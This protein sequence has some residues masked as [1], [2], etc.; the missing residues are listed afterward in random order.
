MTSWNSH[1]VLIFLIAQAKPMRQRALRSARDEDEEEILFLILLILLILVHRRSDR[2]KHI[3]G[4]RTLGEKEIQIQGRAYVRPRH[5]EKV[6]CLGREYHHRHHRG[7]RGGGKNVGLGKSMQTPTHG[8][9]TAGRFERRTE[10][11]P[12]NSWISRT[13]AQ[14]ATR[15][16][17]HTSARRAT[18][19]SRSL[20]YHTRRKG[21]QNLQN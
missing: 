4:V 14:R 1:K 21:C 18:R 12:M 13:N 17:S 19:P 3:K 8:R 11:R 9:A 2:K 5:L 20:L 7:H 15:L 10:R 6:P 16:R